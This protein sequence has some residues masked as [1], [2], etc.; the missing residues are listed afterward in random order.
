[1]GNWRSEHLS[2]PSPTRPRR[3]SSS[4]RPKASTSACCL[5][6]GPFAKALTPSVMSLA[7]GLPGPDLGWAP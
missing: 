5:G 1:M 7:L 3:G 4:G 2:A 6:G